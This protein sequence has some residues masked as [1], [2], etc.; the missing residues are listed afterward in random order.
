MYMPL[1]GMLLI[2]RHHESIWNKAGIWTGS[3]DIHL[4]PFGKEMSYRM[5]EEVRDVR[6]QQA[7]CSMQVRTKETLDEM[8]R[9]MGAED[10]PTMRS[11]AIN[12]RD[13]GDFTGKNKQGMREAL[14]KDEFDRL[15]REFDYPIPHGESLRV[16][17]ERAVP[18]YRNTIVP[19][20]KEGKNVLVVSHGNTLRSIMKYIESISDDD[21]KNVEMP[22]GAIYMYRV[23]EE[24]KLISRE[25][26]H[27][28][29]YES[30]H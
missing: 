26:R 30:H 8:L 4:T 14:G 18:Y 10:V 23:D 20:L 19:L 12:E 16:V 6:I 28:D 11:A 13:Y 2:A 3:R 29:A 17:Y 7:I 21:I 15:H 1:N 27:T 5:G 25:D 24:G 22:F 9:A